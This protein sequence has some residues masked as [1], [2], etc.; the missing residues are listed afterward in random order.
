MPRVQKKTA[1]LSDVARLSQVSPGLV[2]RI[3]NHDP[4]LKIRDETRDR[5]NEAISL[6]NYTPHASAR[7]LRNSRTG[8]LGF[9]LHHVNDPVYADMVASA[10]SAAAAHDYSVMLVDAGGLAERREAFRELVHGRRV[11]GLLIQSGF[12]R[13]DFALHEFADTLP[14]VLFNAE[15]SS[16]LRTVRLDDARAAALATAHLIELGHSAIAFVGA[17]G[18]SSERR[19]QGYLT[20][21][22]SAGRVPLPVI[23]GGWDSDESHTAIRNYYGSGGEAT[24]LVAVTSTVALGAHSGLAASGLTIPNDVSLISIHDTWF[25]RHLTPALTAVSLPL[26]RLGEIAVAMLVSQLDS[27]NVGE[28]VI[29][30]PPPDVIIRGST[31]PARR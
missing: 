14:S 8:L 16:G 13:S 24:G 18:S 21:M 12:E 15:P 17:D 5:V 31:A 7:A 29:T 27:E 23:P 25:A 10:Q 6:L 9:V 11:D 20:A 2:S 3:V 19:Y 26:A 1:R 28:T 22:H 30:D 4:T